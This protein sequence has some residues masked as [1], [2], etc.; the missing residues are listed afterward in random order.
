[1]IRCPHCDLP[2]TNVN[3]TPVKI[4]ARGNQGMAIAYSCARTSCEGV[5]SIGPDIG[6]IAA[7]V[8]HRLGSPSR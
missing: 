6:E 3:A 2:L 7:T 8:A 4:G 1:M 5:L